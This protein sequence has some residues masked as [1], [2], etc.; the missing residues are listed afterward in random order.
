VG[1]RRQDHWTRKAKAE[2][3]PARSVYK[4]EEIDRRLH[5]VRRGQKVLDL[6]AAPGSWSLYL[7][8]LV[9]PAGSVLA[10]DPTPITIALPTQ[11]RVLRGRSEE[12]AAE[13]LA[14]GPFDL[15]VSDMAPSTMGDRGTDQ[16]RSFELFHA[17]VDLALRVGRPG[18]AFVGKIFQGPSFDEARQLL[19]A[20]YAS[21]RIV[22]PQATRRESYEVFLVGIDRHAEPESR[23][24]SPAGPG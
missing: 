7:A 8:G 24:P 4:L 21:V 13:I 20:A 19:R 15:V 17:A 1:D 14:A 5:L 12:L 18:S 22:R 23:L 10:V 9:G 16:Y 3:F 11:V 6:G 2:S